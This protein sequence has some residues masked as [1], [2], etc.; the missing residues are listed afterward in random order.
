MQIGSF[1]NSYMKGRYVE[2]LVCCPFFSFA[3][4]LESGGGAI[5]LHLTGRDGVKP[6]IQAEIGQALS[7]GISKAF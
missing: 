3:I 2:M 1:P 4:E 5:W 6:F 7:E